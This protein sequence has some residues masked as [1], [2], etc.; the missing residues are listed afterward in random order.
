MLLAGCNDTEQSLTS[1]KQCERH[2]KAESY[3]VAA[4]ICA[5]SAHA[6][7]INSQ[8]ILAY[9]HLHKLIPD[10]DYSIAAKWLEEAG[11]NGHTAAQR[12]L[13][14]M[15]LWGRG[16]PR[17]G[18]LAMKWL[19]LAA[20]EQDTQAEFFIGILF[21]GTD[22]IAADQASAI[23][24]FKKAAAR[25]HEMAINNLAWIYATSPNK[26]LRNGALAI[27]LITPLITEKPTASVLL[28]TLAAAY[29]ENEQYAEAVEVQQKAIANLSDKVASSVRDGYVERL[30][31]YKESRPWRESAPDWESND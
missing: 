30:T 11:D 1:A 13:G 16:V 19:K 7:N 18:E 23:H 4:R 29:A 3:Q 6:G 15:Y 12:E 9:I 2:Y 5:E 26:S 22:G 25:D 10:Y 20:R 31:A 14:K 28:D 21:M 27:K 8:W 24:W 17:D